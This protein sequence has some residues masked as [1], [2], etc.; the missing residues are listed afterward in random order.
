MR[1]IAIVSAIA[2]LGAGC[3]SPAPTPEPAPSPAAGILPNVTE[4]HPPEVVMAVG[5]VIYPGVEGSYCY[6]GTCVDK[7]GPPELVNEAALEFKDIDRTSDVAFG[8]EGQ[9]FEFGVTMLDSAGREL[10]LRIPVSFRNDRY[11][12]RVPGVTGQYY[13][14]AHVRF[15]SSGSDDVTYYFPINVE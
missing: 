11:T 8:V 15:G 5:S 1:F 12:V 2:L 14:A 6:S 9:V 10:D 7:I 4:G 13:L 3:F